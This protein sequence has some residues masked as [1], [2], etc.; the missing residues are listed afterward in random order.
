MNNSN[1]NYGNNNQILGSLNRKK[2]NVQEVKKHIINDLPFIYIDDLY[3]YRPQKGCYCRL[4]EHEFMVLVNIYL[5]DEVRESLRIED[6]R[7]VYNLIKCEPSIQF[8][9]DYLDNANKWRINCFNGVISFN[10]SQ[11]FFNNRSTTDIFL[12]SVNANY[13]HN[14]EIT[15]TNFERF[16][17]TVTNGDFELQNLIQQMLGYVLSNFNNAKKAFFLYGK[18]NSGKSVMLKIISLLCGEENISNVELQNLYKEKYTA[19]LFGKLVNIC[20][21]LP[22]KGLKDT[23][24]FK[25][26]VSE[27][28][29]VLARRLYGNPFSFYNKAKLVF[30]TNNLP[31]IEEAHNDNRAFFNRIIIIPFR[32]EILEENQD[33]DLPNKLLGERDYIFKWAMSGLMKYIQNGFKF[34]PCKTSEQALEEYRKRDDSV[35]A[36]IK[37]RCRIQDN[38][39]IHLDKLYYMYE[40]YCEEFSLD[41]PTSKD[42]KHLKEVLIN[43]A[44]VKYKRLNRSDGNKYGF[45]GMV[46]STSNQ[47]E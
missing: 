41:Y 34:S 12:N 45:E 8:S 31:K 3:I 9:I 17:Y 47:V 20:S 21:E 25:A 13:N 38:A 24:I 23:G 29:K 28:D 35:I 15:G 26:L 16:I 30:A 44:G 18:S 1:L 43:V 33:K 40:K 22:D 6:I 32:F 39:Y 46:V 19:E 36:F 10:N 14:F 7:Q 37:D 5:S 11:M 42:K 2:V 4:V 27:T